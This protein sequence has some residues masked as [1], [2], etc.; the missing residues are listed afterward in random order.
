MYNA[1]LYLHLAGLLVFLAAH[2]ASTLVAFRIQ[3]QKDPVRI[4]GMLEVSEATR[5]PMYLSLVALGL[6]GVMDG[7]LGHHWGQ[8]WIWLSVPV[9]VVMTAVLAG[10][11]VPH[12][13]RI[14]R[15]LAFGPDD[16]E[17]VR[18]LAAPIPQIMLA[19]AVVGLGFILWLMLYQ[20]V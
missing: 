14:R 3:R 20:P 6:G 2:G 11:A 13:R 5:L 1:W 19:V 8:L 9:F 18:L 16:Q 12:Y 15:R 4:A 7:I 17:L 10:L